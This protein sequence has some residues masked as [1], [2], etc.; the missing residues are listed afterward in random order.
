LVIVVDYGM[1]NLGSIMNMLQKVGIPAQLSRG[2]EDLYQASKIILPGVGAFDNAMNNL[3]TLGYVDAL[4]RRV[5]VE[6]IP[7]LGICLGMQILCRKSEEGLEPGLGWLDAQVV[8]FRIDGAGRTLKVPHMGWNS[9]RICQASDLFQNPE[10]EHRFYFVHSFHVQCNNPS[11]VLARTEYGIEFTSAVLH[12]NIAATQFHPEKSH[13]YGL[14][15]FRSF[16]TWSPG[17]EPGR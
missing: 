9:I 7:V 13:R 12:R 2:P 5:L 1:G 3:R 16:A 11:D 8:H 17:K 15:F 10:T 14:E 6:E 4:A